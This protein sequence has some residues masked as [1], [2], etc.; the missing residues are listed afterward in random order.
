MSAAPGV[1]RRAFTDLLEV[2]SDECVLWPHGCDA[3]GYGQLSVNQYPHKVHVLV[4]EHHHGPR[5]DGMEVAH[6]CGV[7]N[8]MNSAHLRWAT[9][10]ENVADTVR[11]GRTT[12]GERSASAKLSEVDVL[13]IRQNSDR[14]SQSQLA[15][16]FNVTRGTISD[17]QRSRSWRY[18]AEVTR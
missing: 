17:V 6:S 7:R 11:H 15:K 9:R 2:V 8:C 13:L 12:R 3:H 16:R 4:C 5:P 18:L 10:K 14:L 1:A